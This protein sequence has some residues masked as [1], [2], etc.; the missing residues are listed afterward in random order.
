MERWQS[1]S[2]PDRHG[3]DEESD[4]HRVRPTRRRSDPPQTASGQAKISNP[5]PNRRAVMVIYGHDKE[6]NTALFDWLRAIGLQPREWDQLVHATDNASPYIADV[7][8]QAFKDAQ[9]V[10][11]FFT[12][13]ERVRPRGH[14]EPWRVQARP[15][16]LIE[17]GMALITHPAR[18][19]LVVLGPQELP[20]DL[21]GRHC[22]RLD[23]TSSKPL[24]Q[25]ARRLSDAGCDTDL[26]GTDWVD[27]RRFPDRDSVSRHPADI[28]SPSPASANDEPP[29]KERVRPAINAPGLPPFDPG[30]DNHPND[31]PG[32]DLALRGRLKFLGWPKNGG[33]ISDRTRGLVLEGLA[34]DQAVLTGAHSAL[35]HLMSQLYPDPFSVN[36]WQLH[37]PNR[38]KQMSARWQGIGSAGRRLAEARFN[39]QLTPGSFGNH[40]AITVDVLLANPGRP[41]E[42]DGYQLSSSIATALRLQNALDKVA[43]GQTSPPSLPQTRPFLG[44]RTLRQLMLDIIG[45]L[46]GTPSATLS[47]SVLD[48]KQHYIFDLTIYTISVPRHGFLIKQPLDSNIDFGKAQV[49]PGNNPGQWTH[50]GPIETSQEFTNPDEQAQLVRNWIVQ[51]CIDNG[52]QNFQGEVTDD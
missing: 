23:H 30:A 24:Y 22:I 1:R 50:L 33:Q 5:A 52:F 41:Q 26:T 4:G 28:A 40:L 36:E 18:T 47:A 34:S 21:A 38:I 12:P 17:A 10:I 32:I 2:L 16:V 46:W 9:A 39:A 19:I 44:L 3:R 8:N 43:A 25:L 37:G 48:Q 6:A 45:T 11:A 14:S 13:D 42:P 15:N 31:H 7:L 49:I 27:P 51:L 35:T 20:S 29:D